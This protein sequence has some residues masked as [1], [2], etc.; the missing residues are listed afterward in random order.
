[1]LIGDFGGGTSDFSV[2]R[3]GPYDYEKEHVLAIDGC[4]LAG[5]ALDSLFMSQKLN[6]QFG[7]QSRYRLPMS[8]NVL[9]M[10]PSVMEKL[11][12]PAHIVFLKDK[13]TYEFIREVRK[14]TLTSQDQKYIDQL[15]V[16][17][18]DQQIFSFFEKI[19]KTKRDLSHQ[20][21]SQFVFD[22]P[23]IEVTE[24]FQQSEFVDWA[25]GTKDKIFASLDQC[26]ANAQV[27]AEQIDLV[28]L[29]GGTSQVPLIRK[30]F[31]RRFGAAKLQTQTQFHSVLS[32]LVESAGYLE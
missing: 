20:S 30:E 21:Q 25:Q 24:A 16:L 28:C 15:F 6:I 19:E 32:G 26:L 13:D 2:I 18:E 17:I 4:P 12:Q 22:Y 27:S 7:A 8:E 1:M 11:N 29:T 23:D 31:E 9:K 10:P 5:D 14:C 3:V